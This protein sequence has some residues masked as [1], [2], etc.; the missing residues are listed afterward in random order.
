MKACEILNERLA[1]I[2]ETLKDPSWETLVSEANKIG[3]DLTSYYNTTFKDKLKDY[4]IWGL[5]AA[6]VEIDCLT[7]EYK[8]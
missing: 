8:V 7:G 1:P 6:E 3:V 4:D 2:K 5:T